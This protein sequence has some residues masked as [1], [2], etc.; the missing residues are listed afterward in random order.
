VEPARDYLP[1]AYSDIVAVQNWVVV[2]GGGHYALWSTLDAP[3]A[4]FCR[5]WPG[6][7]SPAHRC[8]L[9]DSFIH[10]PQAAQDYAQNGWIFSQLYNN[11]FGTNFSVSQ[12]GLAVFRYCLTSGEGAVSDPE[13]VRWGWQA[14]APQATMF[15]DRAAPDGSLPPCGQ[16]L[17]AD[18]PEVPVLNWKAAEDG[19]GHILRLWNV[20]GQPQTVNIRFEGYEVAEARLTDLVENDIPASTTAT[21]VAT[22]APSAATP[23]PAAV[24]AF[25]PVA[26][27]SVPAASAS[28][29]ATVSASVPAAASASVPAAISASE[30]ATVSLARGGFAVSVGANEI[31]NVRVTLKAL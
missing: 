15:T 25:T 9:D 27:T 30:P 23:A 12:A 1:G 20:S 6:Y 5:L 31:A 16:F 17:R 7:V 14:T 13:A 19:G 26:S 10:D 21:A 22:V 8:Y 24:S 18:N 4:G 2:Q 29:P 11:N 3:M 28:V